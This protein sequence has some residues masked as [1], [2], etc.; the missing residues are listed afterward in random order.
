MKNILILVALIFSVNGLKISG[1]EDIEFP[2]G[3]DGNPATPVEVYKKY[4]PPKE[5]DRSSLTVDATTSKVNK[6]GHPERDTCTERLDYTQE[7]FDKEIEWFSRS[8]N[9][10]H[11][12]NALEIF[13]YLSEK[14]QFTGKFLVHTWEL[15]DKAFTFPRVRKYD[16]V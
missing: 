4:N 5:S 14:K 6:D 8:L 3:P 16:E 11:F 2:N 7:Q 1:E 12:D 13:E 15:Y 10:T 9:K